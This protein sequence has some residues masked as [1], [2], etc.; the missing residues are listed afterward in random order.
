VCVY[1]SSDTTH[2][3]NAERR[4]RNSAGTEAPA[5]GQK[6]K[7][8]IE[9]EDPA[10]VGIRRFFSLSN[11]PNKKIGPRCSRSRRSRRCPPPVEVV[12]VFFSTLSVS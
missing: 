3:T 11:E 5:R 7:S 4:A 12:V 6:T 9:G 1:P 2:T 10:A 8:C